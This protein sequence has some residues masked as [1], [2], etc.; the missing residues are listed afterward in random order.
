MSATSID[1]HATEPLK[2]VHVVSVV[3]HG[4]VPRR[5]V[6]EHHG[7]AAAV[8]V[9]GDASGVHPSGLPRLPG[10]ATGQVRETAK[11]CVLPDPA[12]STRSARIRGAAVSSRP[13]TTSN[14]RSR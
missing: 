12:R 4:A 14:A 11:R 3:P 13:D 1:E 9:V 2:P 10:P 5:P 7:A 8:S 6:Q